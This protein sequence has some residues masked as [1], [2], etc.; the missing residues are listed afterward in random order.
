MKYILFS[1]LIIFLFTACEK[2]ELT[3]EHQRYNN[4]YINYKT[5]HDNLTLLLSDSIINLDVYIK[6]DSI[7]KLQLKEC[8]NL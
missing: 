3:P 7:Y 1:I 4:C 6:I 5:Q 2:N 8:Q